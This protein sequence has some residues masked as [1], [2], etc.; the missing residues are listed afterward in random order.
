MLG[1]REPFA[2]LSSVVTTLLIVSCG[3]P[4]ELL[5][6]SCCTAKDEMNVP[7]T[8][9]VTAPSAGAYIA[10]RWKRRECNSWLAGQVQT[11][12]LYR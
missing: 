2:Y 10:F 7:I 3:Q 11:V 1:D 12:R 5:T 4:E 9:S 6:N 8:L